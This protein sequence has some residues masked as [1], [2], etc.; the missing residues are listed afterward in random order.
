MKFSRSVLEIIKE[1]QSTRTYDPGKIIEA[2]KIEALTGCMKELS[3]STFRFELVEKSVQAKGESLGTYGVI[4][5]ANAFMVGIVNSEH[6]D[7]KRNINDF[8]YTFEKLILKATELGLGTCWMAAS[9]NAKHF[10]RKLSLK[11]NE[12]IAII[13][14]LGYPSEK[15]SII[16][17][18]T[19]GMAKSN[20]R[21][22]WAEL[23]F[24]EG[25]QIPLSGN[26]AGKY[27]VPLEMVRVSPSASNRQPWRVIRQG[28]S[29]GFYLVTA[30]AYKR[31]NLNLGYNDI[32]ISMCH[33]ELAARE[34]GLRGH[35]SFENNGDGGDDF[36]SAGLE[37]ISC[38]S[39][40]I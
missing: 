21:K 29:F 31:L 33:F 24:D 11:N 26:K 20:S 37:F 25:L 19:R 38:W 35:W 17:K 12:R 16:E 1:R 34:L 9:F 13:T 5:G 8:G 23:F 18:L 2:P 10:L 28:N 40:D 36:E 39:I 14:P 4:K 7:A 3:G 27:F 30:K 6:P 15:R 32:G 22:P